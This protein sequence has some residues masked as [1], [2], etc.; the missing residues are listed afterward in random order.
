MRY[1]KRRLCQSINIVVLAAPVACLLRHR[2]NMPVINSW[3]RHQPHRYAGHVSPLIRA[4]LRHCRRCH[5]PLS[6][7]LRHPGVGS[8]P[9]TPDP[10]RPPT[11]KGSPPRSP[12][13]FTDAPGEVRRAFSQQATS[14][15]CKE[16]WVQGEGRHKK[17]AWACVVHQMCSV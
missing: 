1:A 6:Y 3:L 16:G 5:S 12:S 10:D 15:L 13:T 4:T 14:L 11:W 2:Q 8:T 17:K 7:M 9:P